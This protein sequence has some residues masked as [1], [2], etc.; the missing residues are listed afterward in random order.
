MHFQVIPI[1]LILFLRL[2][3]PAWL[4]GEPLP[5]DQA[6]AV[7][8]ALRLTFSEAAPPKE[9]I[10]CF[11]ADENGRI[12]LGTEARGQKWISIYDA[13]MVFQYAISFHTDGSF[14]VF[15]E[16]GHVWL[17]LVRGDLCVEFDDSGQPVR[18]WE[19]QGYMD[20]NAPLLNRG[21]SPRREVNGTV[22][23]LSNQSRILNLAGEASVLSV[24]SAEGGERVLYDVSDT[25]GLRLG[26]K[27]FLG[28]S[29]VALTVGVVV[30]HH[31]KEES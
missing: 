3:D 30:H 16:G 17:Y 13:D 20:N 27:F 10:L 25:M 4:P 31:K 11:D 28:L 24:S 7:T 5:E 29:L 6:A 9:G 12:A 19:L 8:E 1:L 14:L 26:F 2:L 22:Y 21:Q 23:E 15:L 18:V